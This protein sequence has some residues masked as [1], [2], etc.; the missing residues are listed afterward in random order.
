MSITQATPDSQDQATPSLRGE[1]PQEQAGEK[2]RPVL[3]TVAQAL[4]YVSTVNFI[5]TFV[6]PAI[7]VFDTAA[8]DEGLWHG[9]WIDAMQPLEEIQQ[10]ID[11]LL[12]NRPRQLSN[13][14]TTEWK[15]VD[16]VGFGEYRIRLY[17]DLPFIRQAAWFISCY[18][19]P[20][21]LSVS[22]L[23][24]DCRCVED[25][26][27]LMELLD[28][29]RNFIIPLWDYWDGRIDDICTAIKEH[30]CGRYRSLADYAQ[31]SI[32]GESVIPDQ[33]VI[34]IT[35]DYEKMAQD[36]LSS[37]DIYIIDDDDG[38]HIHVFRSH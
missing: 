36:M 21:S 19:A 3:E 7:Y 4:N 37:G 2:Q 29:Y 23:L 34:Y 5:N 8:Y 32:E 33:L 18:R 22:S 9:V 26:N 31:A 1:A 28:E 27:K 25:I 30:Y 16:C 13:A 14:A 17:D 6:K 10:K 15:I 35:V 24:N 12:A 20:C 38:V 11:E